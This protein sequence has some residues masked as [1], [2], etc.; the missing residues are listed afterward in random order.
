MTKM[1]TLVAI[2]AITGTAALA[3]ASQNV[4]SLAGSRAAAVAD[5]GLPPAPW[6]QGDQG[7]TLYRQAREA[8]NK[9]SYGRAADLFGQLAEKYPG[10]AY[11]PDALYWRAYALNRNGSLQG[12]L[13]ALR[14][15][16]KRF[17]EAA[18][19]GDAPALM[20]RIQG[21]LARSGDAQAAESLRVKAA[22]LD[23]ERGVNPGVSGGVPG[24]VAPRGRPGATRSTRDGCPPED[25]DLRQVALNALME[26]DADQALPVL[27]EVLNRRG[28][29][30]K[31]LR[32]RAV[33]MI[34][35]HESADAANMLLEVIRSDPDREVKMD[36]VFWL[37]QTKDER[38]VTVLDSILRTSDDQEI[39]EKAVFAL[40]QFDSPRSRLVLRGYAERT[41]L[42]E[43]TRAKVI[44]WLGQSGD[45]DVDYLKGLFPKVQSDRLRDAIIQ[46]VSEA[47]EA[48]STKWLL[49]LASDASNSME[50]R[51]K[52]LFWAGQH[53][54]SG[55]E[56]AALYDKMTERELKEHLLFVLSQ[57]S[58]A[59][60]TDK[61]VDIAKN[62]QDRELR[63]KA[64]FWLGQKHDPRIRQILLDII[65]KP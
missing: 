28:P 38:A 34:A 54:V 20:T 40:S 41:D 56:L 18:K 12:A 10:S 42:D 23:R 32:K 16:Q 6:A 55:A 52:A 63:K 4:D 36:A 13:E 30:D 15:Q 26:M 21:E 31:S 29:C 35:Q 50:T 49:S 46:A 5:V 65:N 27:K 22:E 44:F 33:F 2:A 43:E 61:L 17:P 14:L 57:D 64:I 39:R 19:K 8:L 48:E 7:E 37:S 60:A 58:D 11:A 51:K 3:A 25:D 24:G 1:M 47:K 9:G 62:E 59:A 53:G 45:V